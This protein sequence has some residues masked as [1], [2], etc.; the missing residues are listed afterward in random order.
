MRVLQFLKSSNWSEI[1]HNL[2]CA[3]VQI[4]LLARSP[5]GVLSL[6]EVKSDN[7]VASLGW[8][9][10]ARLERVAGVLAEYEPVQLVLA[11]VGPRGDVLLLPVED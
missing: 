10:R 5:S 6:V 1:S 11:L 4:D 8:K 2:E 9:Q 3:H 7:G